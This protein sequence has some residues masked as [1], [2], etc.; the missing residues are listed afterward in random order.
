MIT[1]LD[2]DTAAAQALFQSYDGMEGLG[3]GPAAVL[4]PSAA[5]RGR[6]LLRRVYPGFAVA[7]TI[8]LAATWSGR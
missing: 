1:D 8:A 7:T 3:S 5:A 2:T 4:A 6:E